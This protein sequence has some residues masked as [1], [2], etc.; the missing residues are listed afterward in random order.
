MKDLNS[1]VC[2]DDF[3]KASQSLL[4]KSIQGF[5]ESGALMENTL[6]EN[7]EAFNWWYIRPRLLIDVSD[8][9][10]STTVLGH[11]ISVPFGVAPTGMQGMCHPDGESGAARAAGKIGAVYGLSTSATTDLETVSKEN[12]LKFF[13]LYVYSDK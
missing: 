12:G 7:E 10:L 2:V 9:N 3:R 6:K 11:R 4:P 13:Q 5:Y 8:V 1:L